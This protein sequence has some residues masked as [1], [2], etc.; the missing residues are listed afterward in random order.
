MEPKTEIHL[1]QTLKP[2]ATSSIPVENLKPSE[3]GSL[4]LKKLLTKVATTKHEQ[5]CRISRAKLVLNTI[6]EWQTGTGD[7]VPNGH[8]GYFS[9]TVVHY[10]SYFINESE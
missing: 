5:D 2:P 9:F 10:N 4:L 3:K 7:I 8:E 1:L 6:H